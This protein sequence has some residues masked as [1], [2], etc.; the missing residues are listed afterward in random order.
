M[1]IE[2]F[3]I[4]VIYLVPFFALLVVGDLIAEYVFPRVP[5]LDKWFNCLIGDDYEDD[6]E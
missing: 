1:I 5:F 3:V 2:G 4:V 6:D